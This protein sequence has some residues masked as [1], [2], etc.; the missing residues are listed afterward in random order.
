M[1]SNMPA[2]LQTIVGPVSKIL[3]TF[4]GYLDTLR[5]YFL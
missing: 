4:G 2:R 1:N 3:K 5:M